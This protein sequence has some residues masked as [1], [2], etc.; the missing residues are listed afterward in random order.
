MNI[1]EANDNGI[2]RKPSN[3]GGFVELKRRIDTAQTAAAKEVTC[4]TAR[5]QPASADC[6]SANTVIRV[7]KWLAEAHLSAPKETR[8]NYPCLLYVNDSLQRGR[9][10]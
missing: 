3:R 1:I 9:N 5:P 6:F 10:S 4:K 8:C 7:L 2:G